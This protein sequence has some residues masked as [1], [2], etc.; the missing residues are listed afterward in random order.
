MI[1]VQR[2][3]HSQTAAGVQGISRRRFLAFGILTAAT[4]I[5]PHQRALAAID[6]YLSPERTLSFYNTHTCERLTSTYWHQG[7]YLPEALAEIN[8]LLR[9]HRTDDIKEI[10]TALL[11]LLFALQN[12]L[13]A[14]EPFHIISGYRSPRT[15]SLL[16]SKSKGVVKNSQHVQGRAVDIRL[17][18]CG[19]KML[20]QAAA[21]LKAGGVGYY[22]T[23]NFIHVDVGRVRYW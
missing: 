2:K 4:T 19:L 15:N 16:A 18:K 12:K 22:P 10:D 17:P 23:S 6:E 8:Y 14:C 20:R 13:A 11:D 5:I 21:D 1:R 7:E 3:E 9:D